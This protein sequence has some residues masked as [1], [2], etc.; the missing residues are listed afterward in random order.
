MLDSIKQYMT[1]YGGHPGA[2][3][4]FLF[5]KENEQF[6]REN[7]CLTPVQPHDMTPYYDLDVRPQELS[8]MLRRIR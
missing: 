7:Y 1:A 4:D 5:N 6:I 3:L 8:Q 2:A